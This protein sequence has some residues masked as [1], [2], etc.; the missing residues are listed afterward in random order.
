LARSTETEGP[1]TPQCPAP[2]A[3]RKAGTAALRITVVIGMVFGVAVG[4][5]FWSGVR[6]CSFDPRKLIPP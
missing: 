2:K 6:E 4:V 5:V 1:S 3:G